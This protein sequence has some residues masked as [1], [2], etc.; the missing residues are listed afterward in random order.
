M[1]KKRYLPSS[2]DWLSS[3]I[4]FVALVPVDR[5]RDLVLVTKLEGIDDSDDLIK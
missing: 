5:S 3:E 4:A 1:F 2:S